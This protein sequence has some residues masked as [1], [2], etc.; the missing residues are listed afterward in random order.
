[1]FP[2]SA[3]VSGGLFAVSEGVSIP[4]VLEDD[5]RIESGHLTE[6]GWS[7]VAFRTRQSLLPNIDERVAGGD[8]RYNFLFREGRSGY[9]IAS[10]HR[11]LPERLIDL[12]GLR[13][14]LRSPVVHVNR[15]VDLLVDDP[16]Q[17]CMSQLFAKVNGFGRSLRS[18]LLYGDDL[19]EAKL[20]RSILPRLVPFRVQLRDVAARKDILSIAARGEIGFYYHGPETL[21]EVDQCLRFVSQNR[22]LQWDPAS[23]EFSEDL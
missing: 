2:D 7:H 1:M 9:L 4:S 10:T 11:E 8:Y 13:G 22:L 17:Y 16:Q 23:D 21:T 20:V 5:R 19:A 6:D 12:L 18:M 15:L 14:S 3:N